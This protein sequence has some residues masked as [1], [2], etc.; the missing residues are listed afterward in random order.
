NGTWHNRVIQ[1]HPDT[2]NPVAGVQLPDW[3]EFMRLAASCY[4]LT[5]LGY[6]GVDLVLDKDRGPMM[7]ELNARPGLSIQIANDAGL[8][9]RCARV[10]RSEEHTSELQSRENLV[11]RLLLEK[12]KK[13]Y[14]TL[15]QDERGVVDETRE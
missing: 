3:H 10:E 4:E 12:K 7:L 1:R 15:A 6:L 11:C 13:H 5:G 9:R 2:A 8:A 14:F